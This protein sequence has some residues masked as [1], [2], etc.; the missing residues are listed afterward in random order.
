MTTLVLTC[1]LLYHFIETLNQCFNICI[2]FVVAKKMTADSE[3]DSTH[4]LIC[5]SKVGV[6]TR[7]SIRIFNENSVTSSEKSLVDAI[8]TVLETD[9]NEENVHS[10]VICKKCYKLFNEVNEIS[11]IDS[12]KI[13]QG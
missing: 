6:S 12:Y 9:L 5:N 4:C 3:K 8:C 10:L 2:V 13:I 1:N 7:N 11:I